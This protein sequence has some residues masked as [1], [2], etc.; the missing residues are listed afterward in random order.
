M[1]EAKLQAVGW[2][3][4]CVVLLDQTKLPSEEKYLSFSGHEGVVDSIRRLAVRGAPAI[5]VAGAYAV[6]LAAREASVLP[7]AAREGFFTGAL[8][9]ISEARP[10]A[11]NLRWAVERMIGSWTEGG[12]LLDA[13]MC[14]RLLVEARSIHVEDIAANK[15]MA[16]LGAS[17]FEKPVGALTY[18]NTGDLA[19]AGI[20]TA[21][22]V[23]HYGYKTGKVTHVFAC[24]TRPVMQGM[25]LTVFELS[26]NEIPFTLICDNMAAVM[27]REGK[28]GAVI[29]GADRVAANGDAANKVGTY[30][31]SILAKHHGIPFYI[32]APT[33]TFDLSIPSGEQIPIEERHDSEILSVLGENRHGFAVPVRNP[34]FD[35]TPATLID[36]IICEKGIIRRPTT[37]GVRRVVLGKT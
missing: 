36:A 25:R 16:E 4:G 24:E 32:A 13:G 9:R 23:L 28:I 11:V 31:L 6:A 1:V 27:M 14:E 34:S 37:E 29:T 35:V 10:T 26:K 30:T 20:G 12:A 22:G 5:G 7:V 3:E 33:S 18:C 2:K 8:K 17:L 15:K 19:T 21:F